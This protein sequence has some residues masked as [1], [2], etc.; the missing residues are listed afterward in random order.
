MS[1]SSNNVG[2]DDDDEDDKQDVECPITK[3]MIPKAKI[4]VHLL[5]S[6]RTSTKCKVCKEV[7]VKD[8]KREHLEKWRNEDVSQNLTIDLKC[9][10][11]FDS[12]AES[13]SGNLTRQRG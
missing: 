1:R 3:Q 12:L 5:N 2:L 9:L 13:N 10:Y 6:L 4:G 11:C 8:K 7:I